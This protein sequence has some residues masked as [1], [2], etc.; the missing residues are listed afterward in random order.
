MLGLKL[1]HFKCLSILKNYLFL[2]LLLVPICNTL[3]NLLLLKVLLRLCLDSLFFLVLCQILQ[4]FLLGLLLSAH[5]DLFDLQ[6][7]FL[8]N[9]AFWFKVYRWHKGVL[10]V[11]HE[12]FPWRALYNFFLLVDFHGASGS[13][14][15]FKS[16]LFNL[17]SF[18]FNSF[19]FDSDFFSFLVNIGFTKA[20]CMSIEFH[21]C[22]DA[23][24]EFV[25]FIKL[26]LV[27]NQAYCSQ[28]FVE[29]IISQVLEFLQNF[30][31][32]KLFQNSI[33]LKKLLFFFL[34][35]YLFC[36]FRCDKLI[37]FGQFFLLD[38]GLFLLQLRKH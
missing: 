32:S 23:F 7:G 1:F 20:F 27:G 9:W 16:L 13:S 34:C 29:V 14:F 5:F 17:S 24:V 3:L 12:D 4:K 36:L 26:F 37:N 11:G 22:Q 2:L 35:L 18:L 8:A 19:F 28:Q 10:S 15:F 31:Y 38:H 33:S 6:L 21:D 25:M 30:N